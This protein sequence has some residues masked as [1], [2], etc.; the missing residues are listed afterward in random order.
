VDGQMSHPWGDGWIRH[1]FLFFS[2][3]FASSWP[4]QHRAGV[5]IFSPPRL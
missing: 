1:S 2:F 4:G 5:Q 3:L